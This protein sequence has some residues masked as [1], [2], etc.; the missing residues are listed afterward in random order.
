[1]THERVVDLALVDVHLT[2]GNLRAEIVSGFALPALHA[3]CRLAGSEDRPDQ[4][5]EDASTATNMAVA[6]TP[7]SAVA[8]QRYV[9]PRARPRSA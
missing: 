8:G 3:D 6:L 9:D 5:G 1:V 4:H 7:G 2:I